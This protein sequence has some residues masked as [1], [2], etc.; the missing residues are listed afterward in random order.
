MI[1]NRIEKQYFQ[2]L[3]VSYELVFSIIA[4]NWGLG[5]GVIFLYCRRMGT[6]VWSYFLVLH[7]N[8]DWG[9]DL[10]FGLQLDGDCGLELF[11]NIAG[12]WGLWIGII[13]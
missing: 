7:E 1:L 6:G 13:F 12:K 8:C 4:G 3:I 10:F 2:F 11:F 5:I 9:L